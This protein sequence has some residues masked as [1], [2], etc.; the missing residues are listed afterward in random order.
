M[1]NLILGLANNGKTQYVR[2]ILG[3]KAKHGDNKLLL[4]VP[5]QFSFVTERSLL[6]TMSTKDAQ[7]I[8]VLSFSRLA[9]YVSRSLGG[10]AGT[11]IDDAAKMIIM[12]HTLDYVKGDL[13]FYSKHINSIPLAKELVKTLSEFKKELVTPEALR[14]AENKITPYNNT[15][16][17][18]LHDLA[19]I[20]EHFDAFMSKNYTDEDSIQEALTKVLSENN[21]FKG[22]TIC[23]DAFK[24]F[25][26]REYE[27]IKIL[28]EQADE[29]YITLCTPGIDDKDPNLLFGAINRTAKRL[30]KDNEHK[31]PIVL[32]KTDKELTDAFGIKSIKAETK[33]LVAQNIHEECTYIAATVRKLMREDGMRLSDMAVIARNEEDYRRELISAFNRYDIPVYEDT[34]QPIS[35]QPLIIYMRALLEIIVNG[36]ST[37]RILAYLKT[38]LSPLSDDEVYELENYALLWNLKA[39]D[40]END[41]VFPV[42]GL[43]EVYESQKAHNNEELAKL[44]EYKNRALTELRALRYDICKGESLNSYD[45]SSKIYDFLEKSDV[46]TKLKDIAKELDEKGY[47]ALAS[48]QNSVW[49]ILMDILDNL[50]S[51]YGD[52]TTT[53][54]LYYDIFKAIVSI[55]DL[56]SLPHGLDE[57][58]IGSADRVR[59]D[60]P[61]VTFICGCMQDIFP[62][63]IKTNGL[64]SS[65][66][67]ETMR[68]NGIELS[69]PDDLKAVEERFIAYVTVTSPDEKLFI[70]YHTI[71]KAKDSC[72]PSAIITDIKEALKA[73]IKPI[74]EIPLE[75]FAETDTSTFSTYAENF[76]INSEELASFKESLKDKEIYDRFETLDAIKNK[77]FFEIKDPSIAKEL[78]G[79]DMYLSA[80]KVDTFYHCP[81]QY[82]C[83]YGLD[84]SPRKTASFAANTK[85]SILHFVLERVMKNH[86]KEELISIKD[87]KDKQKEIVDEALKEFLEL[88]YDNSLDYSPRFYN[89]FQRLASPLYSIIQR[90]CD[91]MSLTG[92]VPCA[93]EYKIGNTIKI[94]DEVTLKIT[95]KIDRVDKLYINGTKYIRVVDYKSG[96]KKFVLSDILNGLNMQMLIYLFSL[97]KEE[98][99]ED[100]TTAGIYY[101]KARK[102]NGTN[103]KPVTNYA[104]TGLFIDDD[105]V[106]RAI[107]QD[108]KKEYIA[109][110]EDTLVSLEEMG[111]IKNQVD[112]ELKNM[113]ALLHGGKIHD[114]PVRGKDYDMTCDWCDYKYVCRFEDGPVLEI[115]EKDKATCF[116]EMAGD[117]NA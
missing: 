24:S 70:S 46:Q 21:F 56:G 86:T 73:E 76:Q 92:F 51:I 35:N 47:T 105:E 91:E 103:G 106:Q 17:T 98:D 110:D 38:G 65:R 116:E 88:S 44:N 94:D 48:E 107:A 53:P 60:H 14:E 100:M 80:S 99:Y 115:E 71:E 84:A 12:L 33:L 97:E 29:V 67:R 81:F 95:G 64:L 109:L 93:Y 96:T 61:K 52:I 78:F 89:Q 68:D 5:E 10:L 15:L 74:E 41:F 50:A 11:E 32:G 13:L 58:T 19:I 26:A 7:N 101:Y 75:Y 102:D 114:L 90:I 22:Y 117:N 112:K 42:T 63:V 83:R 18:K 66:D 62:K 79:K 72:F 57:I 3:E 27:I 6:Q 30:L 16:G 9:N 8:E 1:L 108:S 59:L 25:T 82:F 55:T 23:I 4:I 20:F 36:F 37:D 40:W 39:K 69:Y 87:D 43:D 104:G 85:G 45:I 34:R 28:V 49:E 31:E 2:D 77:Q 111:K 113:V 54:K